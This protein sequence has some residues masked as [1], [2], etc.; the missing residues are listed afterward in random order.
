MRSIPLS[1]IVDQMLIC[2]K[3]CREAVIYCKYQSKVTKIVLKRDLLAPNSPHNIIS[4]GYLQNIKVSLP[5]TTKS[6]NDGGL[7]AQQMFHTRIKGQNIS[8]NVIKD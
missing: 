6:F 5:Q 8:R 1:L 4:E 3:I 2:L 7:P